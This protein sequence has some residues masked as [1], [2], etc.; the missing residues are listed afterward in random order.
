METRLESGLAALI[1]AIVPLWVAL[2]DRWFFGRRLSATAI[3]GL[4]IGFAGVA[5]LVRPGG[6]GNVLAMLALVGTTAAWAGGRL[7]QLPPGFDSSKLKF[8]KGK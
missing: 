2:M 7:D 3:A 4:I 6:G 1:V 8:P 5:L